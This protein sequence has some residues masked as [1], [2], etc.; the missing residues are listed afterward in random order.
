M[1][2]KFFF[3]YCIYYTGFMA[4]VSILTF[5][6]NR[7]QAIVEYEAELAFLTGNFAALEA[8]E[9]A[10]ILAMEKA[11]QGVFALS[12]EHASTVFLVILGFLLIKTGV[13]LYLYYFKS[14]DSF[15]GGPSGLDNLNTVLT[16]QSKTD[17][18]NEQK[19]SSLLDQ[20]RIL[21]SNLEDVEFQISATL[22]RIELLKLDTTSDFL[23]SLFTEFLVLNIVLF[24]FLIVLYV[25][26]R[27]FPSVGVWPVR[28]F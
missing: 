1:T 28:F 22:N 4:T 25:F 7:H 20:L 17:L 12:P 2:L 15:L 5:F 21:N 19:I 24:S 11:V 26:M 23:L 16:A 18:L 13:N 8:Q 14:P 3:R 6:I 10:A 27:F 9:R